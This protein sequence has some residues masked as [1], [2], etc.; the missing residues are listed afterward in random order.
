MAVCPAGVDQTTFASI[1]GLPVM[2][3]F[4]LQV[5]ITTAYAACRTLPHMFPLVTKYCAIKTA[6]G[7]TTTTPRKM[8]KVSGDPNGREVSSYVADACSISCCHV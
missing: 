3:V 6:N 7:A 5:S 4:V 1:H 8:G 2:T